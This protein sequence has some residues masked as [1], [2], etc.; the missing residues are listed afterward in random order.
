MIGQLWQKEAFLW[1]AEGVISPLLPL[2]SK[3][4]Q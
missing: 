1:G 2:G 4:N 3:H